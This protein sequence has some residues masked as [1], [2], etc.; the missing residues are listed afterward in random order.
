[1]QNYEDSKKMSCCQILEK[2]E[3]E[4]NRIAQRIFRAM[5]LLSVIL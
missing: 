3:G 1:M 2:R 5:K 4:I